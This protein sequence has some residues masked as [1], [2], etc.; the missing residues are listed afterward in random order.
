MTGNTMKKA[1]HHNPPGPDDAKKYP[2]RVVRGGAWNEYAWNLRCANR[3]YGEHFRR[4]EGVGFR[5][6]RSAHEK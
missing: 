2:Y 1:R 6:C 5:I 3:N 4:F